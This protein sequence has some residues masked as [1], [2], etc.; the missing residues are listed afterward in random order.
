MRPYLNS[1]ALPWRSSLP[2][3]LMRVKN[4][5]V[6]TRLVTM[7][8]YSSDQRCIVRWSMLAGLAHSSQHLSKQYIEPYL[9]AGSQ[10]CNDGKCCHTILRA[11]ECRS[12]YLACRWPNTKLISIVTPDYRSIA[13][14]SIQALS[15]WDKIALCIEPI[16]EYEPQPCKIP[17][18]GFWRCAGRD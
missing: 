18:C 14:A 11:C 12:S 5:F 3:T 16:I 4:N 10:C 2:P 15:A 9:R 1:I 13:Q 8:A 17:P 7:T 6:I